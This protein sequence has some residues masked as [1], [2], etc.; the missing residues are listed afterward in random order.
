MRVTLFSKAITNAN[1][2]RIFPLAKSFC[3]FYLCFPSFTYVGSFFIK[4]I[5]NFL[6]QCNVIFFPSPFSSSSQENW[7]LPLAW[8]LNFLF[9]NTL[10]SSSYLLFFPSRTPL[11]T[12]SQK[13]NKTLTIC[14]IFIF[15]FFPPQTPFIL[16]AAF[17][18]FIT[19]TIFSSSRH[20]NHY[21]PSSLH[22]FF[23][24]S[25]IL[26]SSS[27]F[28]ALTSTPHILHFLFLSL[29]YFHDSFC[30]L[31]TQPRSCSFFLSHL[32]SHF[33]LLSTLES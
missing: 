3:S 22:S 20:A 33:H 18:F 21:F 31:L 29:Q 28:L 26:S 14:F 25:N 7:F 4:C 30:I 10:Y 17:Y 2:G 1:T 27:S 19:N 24:S 5:S 9:A 8:F 6:L 13:T 11:F 15:I 12:S 23:I 32:Y 16:V